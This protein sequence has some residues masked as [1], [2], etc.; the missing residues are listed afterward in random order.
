MRDFSETEK[1]SDKITDEEIDILSDKCESY[2]PFSCPMHEEFCMVRTD[3]KDLIAEVERL[4]ALV[5]DCSNAAADLE[6]DRWRAIC[7]K[8]GW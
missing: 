4:R 7:K 2:H 3:R 8:R 6:E 5:R 1:Q